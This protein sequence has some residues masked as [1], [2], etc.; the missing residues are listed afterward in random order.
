MIDSSIDPFFKEIKIFRNNEEISNLS[1]IDFLLINIGRLDITKEEI[2]RPVRIS[3]PDNPNIFSVIVKDKSPKDMQVDFSKAGSGIEINF[4][5][6]NPDDKIY[7]SVYTDKLI[8]N[9][10]ANAGIKNLTELKIK[11]FE[12]KKS[13][14]TKSLPWYIWFG[15]AFDVF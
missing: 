8:S 15:W 9:F 5:L 3:F 6:M 11:T 13:E 12:E 7:F 2:V 10:G 14:E 1:K 4:D